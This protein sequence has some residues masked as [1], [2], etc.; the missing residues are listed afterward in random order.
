MGELLP[1]QAVL[2]VDND[3]FVIFSL[4]K[5]KNCEKCQLS[6]LGYVD[7]IANVY[8]LTSAQFQYQQSG[9]KGQEGLA[10]PSSSSDQQ[11]H[12]R[13]AQ[14]GLTQHVAHRSAVHRKCT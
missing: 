3:N 10:P 12:L 7:R 1:L 11:C 6:M 2:A 14:Q 5:V 9:T 4:H 13:E 8:N